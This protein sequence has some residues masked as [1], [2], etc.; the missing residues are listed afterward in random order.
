MDESVFTLSVPADAAHLAAVR[1]FFD[2]L[3]RPR[4]GD[5]TDS[6]VLALDEACANVI[7]HRDKA[8]HCETLDVHAELLATRVLFRLSSFCSAADLPRIKPRDLNDVRPGGLGTHFIEKIMDRV[9]YEN[10]FGRPDRLTLVLEKTIPRAAED[11]AR[12][13]GGG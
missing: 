2:T 11:R 1:A 13:A 8:L 5:A 3:L 9:S 12:T 7:R 4:C 6:L 10:E